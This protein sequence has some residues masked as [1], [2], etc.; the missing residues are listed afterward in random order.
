MS[1]LCFDAAPI[2]PVKIEDKLM[3]TAGIGN[4][5]IG[6]NGVLGSYNRLQ[7]QPINRVVLRVIYRRQRRLEL[8][9]FFSV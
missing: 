3:L 9:N 8:S 2:I 5:L 4:T 1:T 7:K 6:T